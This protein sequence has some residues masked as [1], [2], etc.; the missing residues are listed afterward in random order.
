MEYF[1]KYLKNKKSIIIDI[2]DVL[3]S[4]IKKSY[5]RN[6]YKVRKSKKYISTTNNGLYYKL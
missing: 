1:R 4:S 5:L 3:G 2:K 6:K